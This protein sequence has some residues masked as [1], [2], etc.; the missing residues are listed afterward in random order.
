MIPIIILSVVLG[1]TI[2]AVGIGSDT[3]YGGD[4]NDTLLAETTTAS[5]LYGEAGNDTLT[6]QGD[7][8]L[9]G[10]AGN[11]V[12]NISQGTGAQLLDGGSGDDV[13]YVADAYMES[14][15]VDS[16]GNDT[17]DTTAFNTSS[18]IDF[19]ID[20][21]NNYASTFYQSTTITSSWS[22]NVIENAKDGWGHSTLVGSSAN[23]LLDGGK[24]NDTLTGGAGSDSLYGGEGND[25][26]NFA[27]SEGNDTISDAAGT[28]DSA[29]FS[30][31]ATTGATWSAVDGGDADSYVDSLL[32]NFGTASVL[33]KDF[34]SN[35]S[36]EGS[37]ST[38]GTGLIESLVFSDDSD[39]TFADAQELSMPAGQ[40]QSGTTGADT[41]TGGGGHD[42]LVGDAGNDTL[43]GNSGNDTL[44]GG[45]GNDSLTGDAG[46][47]TLSGGTENDTLLGGDGNDSLLGGTGDD[48]LLGGIGNDTLLGEDGNDTLLGE[49][50]N[51]SLVGGAGA[52][53]LLGGDGNDSLNGGTGNDTL[54]GGNGDDIYYFND[55]W[56]N[57]S[58]D[59]PPIKRAS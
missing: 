15:I 21:A 49:S 53:S 31:L 52:D 41:L 37:T 14:D 4:G 16:Y 58:I 30:G 35:T 33:I 28:A 56:G 43:I 10:G 54:E 38:Y 18:A 8:T 2:S 13:Y 9:M 57:D 50:G 36:L 3:L 42:T 29:V 25:R 51:D 11:D 26:Y 24:G 39:V 23:N 7:S 19:T 40:S 48:S 44:S 55:G 1:M 12:M 22:G 32:V 27:A 20:L 47:D 59:V 45:S 5:F 34:F 6:G 17:F 46:N